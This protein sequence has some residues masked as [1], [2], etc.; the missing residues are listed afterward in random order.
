MLDGP[1]KGKVW[2]AIFN[3]NDEG[4]QIVID[5]DNEKRPTITVAAPGTGWTAEFWKK[6]SK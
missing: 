4:V 2:V 5:N 1:D 3:A 6:V